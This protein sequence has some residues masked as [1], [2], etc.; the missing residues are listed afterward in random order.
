MIFDGDGFADRVSH[1]E[2]SQWQVQKSQGAVGDLL[3]K[4]DNGKG[5]IAKIEYTS[6]REYD[7]TG[8]DS[9]SDLPFPVLTVSSVTSYDDDDTSTANSYTTSYEYEGGLYDAGDREFRGFAHVTIK[10]PT[11]IEKHIYHYQ[12]DTYK[13]ESISR[14]IE[15]FFW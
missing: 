13:R 10:D 6:S 15:R 2:T 3:E 14:G 11:D 7:N 12:D 4:I 9:I 5:G 1:T 8:D